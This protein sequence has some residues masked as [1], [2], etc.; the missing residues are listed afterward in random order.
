[1]FEAV[2]RSGRIIT[3]RITSGVSCEA[4]IALQ[5]GALKC[6]C[7]VRKLF[8]FPPYF[9]QRK[10]ESVHPRQSRVAVFSDLTKRLSAKCAI[11]IGNLGTSRRLRICRACNIESRARLMP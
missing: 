7:A 6:G 5:A 1:A 2:E 9:F 11:Q 10:P 4:R 3:R 8:A